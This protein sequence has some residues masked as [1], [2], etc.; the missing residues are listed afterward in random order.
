[1]QRSLFV[2]IPGF[3]KPNAGIKNQIL[4]HNVSKIMKSYNWSKIK[5]RICIYDET[6]LSMLSDYDDYIEVVR[7]PGLPGDFIKNHA[8]PDDVDSYDYVLILYDDI[9]LLPSIDIKGMMQLKE[10]FKLDVVS[11]SLSLDSQYVYEYMR[12]HP[13]NIYDLK[14]SP[15]CELFC[16]FMDRDAYKRYYE[17]V[18]P[19]NNPWLW[20]LDLIV[21]YKLKLRIGIM[22]NMTMKHLFAQTCYKEYPTRDPRDGFNYTMTKYGVTPQEL[23]AQPEAMFYIKQS[24]HTLSWDDID[25]QQ[26]QNP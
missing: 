6:P 12:T 15:C 4:A 7:G 2:I 25:S 3:G 23:A 19:V 14:I 17:H 18:D 26:S 9:L 20:G 5:F 8:T 21:H 16:Y 22:N 1:M 11:P 10:F 13:E 24:S